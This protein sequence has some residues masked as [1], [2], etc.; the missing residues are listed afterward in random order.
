MCV[1]ISELSGAVEATIADIDA[2]GLVAPIL[3]HVGDG[4]FHAV[5]LVDREDEGEM[6]R[7]AEVND[8]MIEAALAVGG[9]CTGEHGIGIGKASWLRAQHGE[10]VAVM[11]LLK[12]SLDPEGLL[13]PGKVFG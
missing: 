1:P 4:N 10:G 8:R 5:F 13:N 2:E 9:T 6:R 12:E 3:G 11:R 7:A